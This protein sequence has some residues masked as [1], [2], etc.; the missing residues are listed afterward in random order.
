[1]NEKISRITKTISLIALT[2]AFLGIPIFF[3]PITTDFF[4]LN[5]FIFFSL[6]T[7]VAFISWLVYN[8]ATKSVRLTISPLLLPIFLLAVIGIV[9]NLL[10]TPFNPEAWVTRPALYIGIFI[11]FWLLT[12]LINSSKV[13]K[14]I[15]NWLIVIGVVLAIQ[16]LLSIMG[17]FETTGLSAYLTSKM[18]TPVGSP[19]TLVTFLLTLIPISLVLA[20]KGKNGPKK[21]AYFISSGL[22]ISCVILIGSQI[23]P[24]KPLAPLLLPQLSGWSIAIDTLKTKPF[25]GAG[26]AEYLNQFTQFKPVGLNQTSLWNVSFATSSNEYL[27]LLTTLGFAGLVAFLLLIYTYYKLAKRDSG[28]RNTSLQTAVN[29]A[30]IALFVLGLLV[31]FSSLHW[32]LLAGYLALC[33]GLN[34]A[35]NLTK[36]KDVIFTLNAITVVEPFEANPVLSASTTT[37][38]FPILVAVPALLAVLFSGYKISRIYA[39]EIAFNK[40]LI[41]ANANNGMDTYNFQI[42]TIQLSPNVDRYHTAYSNTNLALAS[43]L[44]NQADL[45]DQ[46]KQTVT[47]L[48]QQSVS[49]AR[50]ATQLQP[51]KASNWANL[52]TI[53]RQLINFADGA[54]DFSLAAYIQAVQL[55]PA[56]P[57]LRLDLGGLMYS[58]GRY[59]EAIARF[60]EATQLKPD[61]ANAYYNLSHAYSQQQKYLEAYQTMQSVA[62]LVPA[63]SA[64]AVTV[65]Q[66]LT[67]L[68]AKLPQT[69]TTGTTP[70]QTQ[71]LAE[72]SP[73]PEAPQGLEPI[74]LKASPSPTAKP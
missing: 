22:I 48:I 71:Q 46:D 62:T 35:K 45:S 28:T 23:W 18:F 31:P 53:Y 63:D 27:T 70:K 7:G 39:S 19:L 4:Q 40:S 3:L 36:V 55:D 56:N 16:G 29:L 2:I 21:L 54:Q 34:K 60:T 64:D 73:L 24:K 47:Q 42:K 37:A 61:F 26:P 58:L 20:I 72:P 25:L 74:D 44:S 12:T 65:Q 6:T 8:L 14:K 15:L 1:M 66:E 43:A 13:A 10:N 49:E 68:K 17:A 9:S 30:I 32:I 51:N 52:A 5:K 11:F 50:T 33:V 38:V 57:Q 41:A 59:D 67:D 69:A